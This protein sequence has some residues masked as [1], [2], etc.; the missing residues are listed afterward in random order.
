MGL[1]TSPIQHGAQNLCCH[2]EAAGRGVDCD[3]AGHKTDVRED[4]PE[5]SKL[6][7]GQ[8]FERRGVDDALVV[9]EAGSDGISKGCD[10]MQ[11]HR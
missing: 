5:V 8:R 1:K 11:I 3:I 9:A 6:L 2:H 10:V 7:V 4:F